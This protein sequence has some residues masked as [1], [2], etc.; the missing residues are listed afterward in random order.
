MVRIQDRR[1][2]HLKGLSARFSEI[3]SPFDA[4]STKSVEEPVRRRRVALFN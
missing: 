2:P 3:A 1:K 4:M